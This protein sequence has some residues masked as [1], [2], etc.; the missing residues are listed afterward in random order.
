MLRALLV[1]TLL[2]TV[3][4]PAADALRVTAVGD[5]GAGSVARANRDVALAQGSQGL[6]GTGDY[7]DPQTPSAW[8]ALFDPL[9]DR[10]RWMARGNH[11]NPSTLAGLVAYGPVSRNVGG[12][13]VVI[14]D[15]QQRVDVG[16]SQYATARNALCGASEPMRVL[17][18]HNPWWLG[19]GAR[20]PSWTFPGS[21]AA[22]DALVR[23]CK[24]SLVL[25]G[26]EHNYQRLQRGAAT[27]VVVGT[28]GAGLYPLAGVPSGTVA[29]CTCYG[30][31]RLDLWSTGYSA[32]FVT[33][34][35]TT[36][37][38]FSGSASSSS[39]TSGAVAF[40]PVGGNEWWA[41]VHV[42][43]SGIVGVDARDTGGAWVPLTLRSWGDWAGSFHVEPG[44]LVQYRA[45][46]ASG[47]T[48]TSC[49]YTHPGGACAA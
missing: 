25:S 1:A 6:L 5:T 26:H 24:V 42:S 48:P 40:R 11:D 4:V 12:A 16:T 46:L 29:T 49:W 35:W 34:G 14:L 44:H 3:V 31:L 9:T 30:H 22:M 21:P 36:R 15:T 43:G 37:D 10:G 38:S 39:S 32:A 20:H 17:V 19:A 28:G 18:A 41:Q 23:D 8:L 45:R 33:T 7:A 47:A 13:R 27:Y 2:A